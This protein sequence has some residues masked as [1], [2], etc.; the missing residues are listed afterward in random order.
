MLWRGKHI[1]YSCHLERLLVQTVAVICRSR[2]EELPD[3]DNSRVPIR[4]RMDKAI[5]IAVVVGSLKRDWDNSCKLSRQ[6][7][8]D[9]CNCREGL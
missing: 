6:P 8:L 3:C 1:Q 4:K 7:L 9:R 5:V 2:A